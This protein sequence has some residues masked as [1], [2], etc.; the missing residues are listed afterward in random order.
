MEELP[1]Y[2]VNRNYKDTL[3]RLIFQD[4][5][6]LLTL[7]NAVSGTHYNDPE[8]LELVTLE[9]AIYINMKNDLAFV[10]DSSLHLYEHQS[11]NSPNMPLRNLFYA[12]RELEKLIQP[13]SLY[14]TKL[15]TV[16][17]PYFLVF[18][19]GA[20][21]NW[22]RK[23]LRLSDAY[24][25]KI[26]TPQLELLV[27]MINI[28]IGKNDEL[29]KQCDTLREYMLFVSK[30]RTY[31]TNS[32][33]KLAVHKAVNESIE[34]G[35]LSDFLLKYKS[36]AIQMSILEYTE[37]M[38]LRDEREYGRELGLEEGRTM[39][40]NIFIQD[41][42]EEHIPKERILEKLKNKFQVE[43][44]KALELIQQVQ[45]DSNNLGNE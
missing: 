13:Q 27:H 30:V 2:Q 36:E 33:F 39:F 9:N 8:A 12:A 23:I 18:Y 16:P 38:L 6:R 22:S 32:D 43:E 17:T 35:I 44:G 21:K 7:Y 15:V 19:N 42:L 40:I 34:E 14:T 4:K 28:N 20:D 3:F 24:E 5:T 1:D 37:E 26:D 29:L 11:T 10:I 25:R 41:N 45:S 31:T